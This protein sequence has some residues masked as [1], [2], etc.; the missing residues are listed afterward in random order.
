MQMTIELCNQKSKSKELPLS[1]INETS[2]RKRKERAEISY[3]DFVNQDKPQ[4]KTRK[5]ADSTLKMKNYVPSTSK[6][7]EKF[8]ER[9]HSVSCI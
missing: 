8:F 9:A 3:L 1:P 6:T 7:S 4:K 2:D 5:T